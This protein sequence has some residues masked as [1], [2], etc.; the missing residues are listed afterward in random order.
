MDYFCFFYNYRSNIC[1][2]SVDNQL[3]FTL[4]LYL[5]LII[6]RAVL[7]AGTTINSQ[8]FHNKIKVQSE[9]FI[10]QV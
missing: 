7:I 5:Y 8:F 9:S 1:S 2:Y 6:I 10:S 3:E 4:L